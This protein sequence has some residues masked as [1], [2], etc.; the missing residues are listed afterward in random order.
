MA[1]QGQSCGDCS[2]EFPQSVVGARA[3]E[4]RCVHSVVLNPS[5]GVFVRCFDGNCVGGAEVGGLN[6]A[7][8]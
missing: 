2:L 6:V 1:T 5:D 8:A 3:H 7:D 4:Q